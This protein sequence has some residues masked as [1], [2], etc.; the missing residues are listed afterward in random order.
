[1]ATGAK[2]TL[3]I[4]H[5]EGSNPPA[6]HLTRSDG[7][8]L[9]PVKILTPYEFPVEGSPQFRLM[10]QLRWYLEH[11]L[12]Y[13][14]HPD[15]IAAEH[16]LD[17]LKAWG[18]QAFN[19]IFDRGHAREWL[20]QSNIIQIKSDDPVVLSW[21]WEA[22]FDPVAGSYVV[23]QS[24]ME[25]QL[26]KLPDPPPTG[27]L[28]TDRIN[29][30]LVV[31]RPY[32][33]DVSYRSIARPLV[34]LIRTKDLP[35]HVDVLRPPTFDQLRTHLEEHPNYYH[36]LHFDGHGSYGN[37]PS[38]SSSHNSAQQF[39][40]REGC[41]V[42]EDEQGEA[43][44]KSAADLTS[45]LREYAVPAVVL[46]ACQSGT[47][48]DQA[49]D[50]FATVATALLQS[51][52]RSVVAMAYSLYV[53]GAQSFLP[54]FY[55]RLFKTG[56]IAEGV[57]A[58]RQ[59]MLSHKR[60]TSPR[61]PYELEDWLLPVLYQQQPIDFTFATQAPAETMT[62]SRESRLPQEV[63]NH[64]DDYDFVGRDGPILEMERA[65]HLKTPSIL[66][67]GL[68]GVGKTTL[69]R[70]FLRWLDE[71]GGLDAALWF[72]FRDIRSAEY[73]LNRTGQLFYGENFGVAPDK[74]GLLAN[75]MR[76]LRVVIVWDNFESATQNLT[77]ED[78]TELGQFL[79]AIRGTRGKVIITSRSTEDWLGPPRRYKLT[80]GGLHG[81]ER[82][83][84]CESVL[85]GLGLK[86]NRDDSNLTKLM[87]QLMGHPLAMRVVLP[88]LERMPAEKIVD[89]LRT[90]IADLG[91]DAHEEEGRVFAT[92]RFVE[93]GLPG[94][95]RPLIGLVAMHEGY[96]NITYLEGMAIQLD[97]AW[98]RSVVDKL[99]DALVVAGLAQQVGRATYQIHPL[100]TSYLHS[101]SSVSE[102][103][104]R[105][106]V[107]EMAS[108]AGRLALLDQDEQRMRFPLH[109][110]N[111]YSA[112]R[113]SIPLDV[114]EGRAALTQ[115][116]AGFALVATE[117]AE[118]SRLYQELAKDRS[119][120]QDPMGEAAAYHQLG[121]VA[122]EQREFKSAEDW[123]LKSLAVK[124][125]PQ[126]SHVGATYHQLGMIAQELKDFETA[127]DWYLKSLAIAEKEEDMS[128][129][130]SEHH[131]LGIVAEILGDIDSAE[132]SYLK[133]L[134]IKQRLN[135]VGELAITWTGLAHIAELREE[136]EAAEKLYLQAL[137]VF[138]EVD[139]SHRA[140]VTCHSLGCLA[141]R[142]EHLESAREWYFRSLAI[143]EG[144]GYWHVAAM[145]YHQLGLVAEQQRDFKTAG[146]WYLKSL[147][148]KKKQ[149][150][151][152]GAA[153]TLGQ[154][155]ILAGLEGNV[156]A[157]AEYLT[158]SIA[159]FL[160]ANDRRSA[161]VNIRNF[162]VAYDGVSPEDQRK[163][164]SIWS[165]AGLGP[166][167]T[168]AES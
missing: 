156:Q 135:N 31:A 138:V 64:R 110:S 21:P 77:G 10:R 154:L 88:L 87:D 76:Q 95:L 66:V 35:A 116:L 49:E 134:A 16:V 107:D 147:D 57:R 92:L 165:Q 144:R 123:Y 81:E 106:F 153:S 65:L 158:R 62:E 18:S 45:L 43:D 83:E 69:A 59:Q 96:L 52:M 102:A 124:D 17:A 150:D 70:G 160:Q 133:S 137:A 5:A 131:Q 55:G 109:R 157:C 48:D 33:N 121:R 112:L 53:S 90:N 12:D 23:L 139:D 50:P 58:G 25:R 120:H 162:F 75:A 20:A 68:G 13:P 146:E 101:Q 36:L 166:F 30:L 82:W 3:A 128:A 122:E 164:E 8:S 117:F 78:R 125:R 163:M 151:P 79:D 86:V 60:R 113:A 141:Q 152:H 61:G 6:F 37:I 32:E 29:I 40:A 140:G 167:P 118:A 38:P 67:Q 34:D 73:V 132:A 24:R 14:Y 159:I 39:R 97:P 119:A 51:G 99:V 71:T 19:A 1:M 7:K 15:T 91:L 129:I 111:F 42:F 41:L 84:Y 2:P 142:K 80:L 85:T 11:F 98:T 130:A 44:P 126:D 28:P 161:E 105:A 93:R 27:D 4:V 63:L 56:S 114:G 54:S 108:A 168:Q 47:L 89:A 143:T 104:Q 103:C 127:T 22:L 148:I 46:N 136:F 72:D 94:E 100:L 115:A 149:S 9:A 155:G 145:T 26:N 74:L